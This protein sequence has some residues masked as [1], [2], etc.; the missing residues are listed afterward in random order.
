MAPVHQPKLHQS[1]GKA[2]V[3]QN[4]QLDKNNQLPLIIKDQQLNSSSEHL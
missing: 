1:Q 3:I 2:V 4:N